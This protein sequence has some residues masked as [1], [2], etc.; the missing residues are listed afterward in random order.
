MEIAVWDPVLQRDGRSFVDLYREHLD[1]LEV[2]EECGFHH[3]W[4][5][6]HHFAGRCA[7]PSPNLLI[8]AA[9]ERTSR[10]RLGTMVNVL[11]YRNPLILAEELAMLD[12]LT[13]GRLD[14]G[15]G[16][17]VNPADFAHFGVPMSE[18]RERFH[19]SI[20]VMCRIWRDEAF[21]HAGKYFYVDKPTP[22]TPPMVQKPYPPL[23][24]TAHSDETVRWAAEHDLYFGQLDALISD[25]RRSQDLYHDVQVASGYARQPRLYVCREVYVAESAAEAR[26]DGYPYFQQAW[27]LWNRY[28][29]HARDGLLPESYAA[30]QRQAPR[31]AAMSYEEMIDNDLVLVGDPD[32][33]ASQIARHRR[34]L[35]LAILL[36]MFQP[37]GMPH[38]KVVRSMRLFAEEVLPHAERASV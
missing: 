26:R 12:N 38:E 18:S 25:C 19:E 4:F 3:V 15:I 24:A 5:I 6:E 23:F 17:G 13:N 21:T 11:P 2:A 27:S 29:Q 35:D 22:L 1:E 14:I 10:I 37:G 9:A 30:W 20:D 33:V 34:D 8:A 31:L 32:Q 7:S 28:A 16:R 36:C